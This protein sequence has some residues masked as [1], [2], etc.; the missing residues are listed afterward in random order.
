V[1]A[2]ADPWDA[3]GDQFVRGH[4]GSLRGEVRTYVI[5]EHLKAHL[6]PPPAPVVDI[7]GGAGHQSLPL[8]AAGYDV[9]IVD[10]SP[11]MLAR[12]GER[13]AAL[14][15][16][17]GADD[18][19]GLAGRVRMVQAAGEDAPAALAGERFAGVLCHGVFMYLDDPQPMV[20]ALC[21]L[22]APGGIV[23]IAAK[24]IDAM[25]VR[26]ALEGDWAAAL[27]VLDQTNADRGYQINGLG[28]RTRGDDIEALGS[29][30]RARGVEPVDWYG[31]RLFSDG[32]T[33]D[34]PATDP[35]EL[36]LQVELAASRR[37][38]YRGLS[39]LFHL[40]GRRPA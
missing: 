28:V 18:L 36:V 25:A 13:I 1:T 10:P 11:T 24:N 20:D 39:R 34:R 15:G 21:A 12:A 2:D 27:A 4:Y 38:P 3:L 14:V 5:H 8:A 26:P 22:T 6:P 37:D 40:I 30:L 35:D 9:T 33:R 23:S 19:A 31:V 17:D 16:A 29:M 7:G 32:W